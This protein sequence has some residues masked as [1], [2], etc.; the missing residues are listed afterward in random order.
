[1]VQIHLPQIKAGVVPRRRFMSAW[2]QRREPP[3]K[4]YQYLIVRTSSHPLLIFFVRLTC[5][6]FY[7]GGDRWLR[8]RTKR[9]RSASQH[10]RL[11][12]TLTMGA[13]G[14][15]HTGIQTRSSTASSS[16][17]A[18]MPD[19]NVPVFPPPF[20]NATPTRSRV[21]HNEFIGLCVVKAPQYQGY[22]LRL[23]K[24]QHNTTPGVTRTNRKT[25]HSSFVITIT[26]IRLRPS[27]SREVTPSARLQGTR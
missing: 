15:G 8:S 16:C 18:K 20:R 14:I 3:N 21:D 24:I 17:S 13:T 26:T 7:F 23:L 12:T 11:K 19:Y 6:G 2:E 25:V 9:L 27:L 4:S 5:L 10:G 22:I 1:M